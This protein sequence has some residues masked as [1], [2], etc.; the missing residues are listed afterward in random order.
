MKIGWSVREGITLYRNRLVNSMFV[1]VDIQPMRKYIV[2]DRL[3]S[4]ITNIISNPAI[5]L[6]ASTYNKIVRHG[7][8]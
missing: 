2:H 8:R 6:R 4:I 5:F 7:N 1:I 3:R